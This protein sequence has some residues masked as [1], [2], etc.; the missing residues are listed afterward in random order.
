MWE[1]A[2]GSEISSVKHWADPWVIDKSVAP[3]LLKP[4]TGA[5]VNVN[6]VFDWSD[7]FGANN[8]V[9]RV[10]GIL[11]G[12]QPFY[13]PLNS[14]QSQFVL[15]QPFFDILKNGVTYSWAIAGTTLGSNLNAKDQSKLAKLSYSE[16][17]TF[18]KTD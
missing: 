12:S 14:T 3:I 1:W 7:V 5:K 8:Y 2:V 9:A 17:R 16:I 4:D 6:Q 13:F 10:T 15:T 11:P 18:T